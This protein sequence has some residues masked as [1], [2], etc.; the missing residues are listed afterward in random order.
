MGRASRKCGAT[1]KGDREGRCSKPAGWGTDHPGEG[2]CK[3]HGGGTAVGNRIAATASLET[4]IGYKV[5][6]SPLDALLLCVRIAA[7]EVVLF[8][9]K[10]DEIDENELKTRP[11]SEQ[12]DK[13]GRVHDLKGPETLNLWMK[14]RQ[15]AMDRLTRYSKMALDAGV[16]ERLVSLAERAGSQMAGLLKAILNELDLDDVQKERAPGIVR[17]HLLV[18]EGGLAG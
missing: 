10:L 8:T 5:N 11:R 7:A 9:A 14:E 12:L 4:L 6:V 3:Y 15:K 17:K 13:A 1:L 18:L 2:Q 16:E